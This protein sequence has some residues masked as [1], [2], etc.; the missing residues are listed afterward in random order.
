MTGLSGRA[1]RVDDDVDTDA[2][3]ASGHLVKSDPQHWAAHVLEGVRPELPGL[4]ASGDLIVAGHSFGSGSSREHAAIAIREA[5]VAAVLAESF[6]RTF[7]RNAFNNGLLVIEAP[8]IH[9]AV[10]DGDQLEVHLE[11]GEVRNPSR[12]TSLAC[13]PIPAFLLSMSRA[14][15]LIPWLK[16]HG[17]WTL[18]AAENDAP[19]A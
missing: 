12:G 6:A 8:G 3:I 9:A 10:A 4:L 13:K 5:G 11:G 18:A 2:I 14:G 15:G 16:A 1:W 7:Y 17:E 19:S